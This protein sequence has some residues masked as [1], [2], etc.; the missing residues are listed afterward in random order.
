MGK[1]KGTLPIMLG[2][3]E[4]PNKLV[5]GGKSMFGTGIQVSILGLKPDAED[6]KALSSLA[7][8]HYCTR[9]F[10]PKESLPSF[11]RLLQEVDKL[12]NPSHEDK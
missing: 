11:I 8:K 2:A 10:C 7:G 5:V 9:N 4:K 1:S 12:W 6:L 3:F